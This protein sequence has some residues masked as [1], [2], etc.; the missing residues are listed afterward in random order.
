M[1]HWNERYIRVH[2][3]ICVQARYIALLMRREDEQADEH[4]SVREPLE[5][6]GSIQE[7]VMNY[8]PTGV[9]PKTQRML[10]EGIA[11]RS[12]LSEIFNL[13]KLAPKESSAIHFWPAKYR[14]TRQPMKLEVHS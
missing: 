2:A 1:N 10:T 3:F 4:H 5:Q 12:D 14:L 8:S 6:F 11:A 7:T 9:Q 13:G